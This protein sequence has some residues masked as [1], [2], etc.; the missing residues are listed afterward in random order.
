MKG[1]KPNETATQAREKLDVPGTP[2]QG[3]PK[4]IKSQ[5]QCLVVGAPSALTWTADYNSVIIVKPA[6]PARCSHLTLT[7]P[8]GMLTEL[9]AC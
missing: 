2:S 5:T 7:S 1:S 3:V 9:L 4:N 8:L 6:Y